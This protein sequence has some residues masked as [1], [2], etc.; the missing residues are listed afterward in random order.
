MDNA[1]NND[2]MLDTIEKFH[3]AEGLEFNAEKARFRC[4]PHTIHL[5]ALE[6][7]LPLS[8]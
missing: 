5:S 8:H 3:H 2:T 4:V 7:C 1:T 6:V